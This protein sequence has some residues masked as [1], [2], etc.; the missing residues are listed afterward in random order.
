MIPNRIGWH[1]F[2]VEKL[3]SLLKE[4]TSKNNGDFYCLNYLYSFRTKKKESHKKVCENKDF[5]NIVMPSGETKIL[6]FNEYSLFD[7]DHLLFM[8]ILNV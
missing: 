8:Q 2:P 4:I 7:K 1:Y 3:T 5:C 6:E